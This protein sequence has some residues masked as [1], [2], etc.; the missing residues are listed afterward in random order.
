MSLR[1]ASTDLSSIRASMWLNLK[2]L[3]YPLGSRSP[4]YICS[5]QTSYLEGDE[6]IVLLMFQMTAQ[7]H[8]WVK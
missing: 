3:L 6:V 2:A 5:L 1:V 8:T 7:G 4:T